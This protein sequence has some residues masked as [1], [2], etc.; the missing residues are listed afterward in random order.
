MLIIHSGSQDLREM[1]GPRNET[2]LFY[3]IED[4]DEE[5]S[6]MIGVSFFFFNIRS[7]AMYIRFFCDRLLE[8]SQRMTG[9]LVLRNLARTRFRRRALFHAGSDRPR[10]WITQ[11]H[12]EWDRCTLPSEEF[13][14]LYACP[15]IEA[16]LFPSLADDRQFQILYT[17]GLSSNIPLVSIS[18]SSFTP[19]NAL[20]RYPIPLPNLGLCPLFWTEGY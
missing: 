20:Y 12:D 4:D 10:P 14:T 18:L 9:G 13:N 2:L 16:F 5:N 11:K 8:D 19:E 15:H 6:A 7:R 1:L 17:H 3:N